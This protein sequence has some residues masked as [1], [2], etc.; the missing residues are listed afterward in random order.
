MS[1]AAWA[2]CVA[3]LLVTTG[4]NSQEATSRAPSSLNGSSISIGSC[5]H[6]AAQDDQGIQTITFAI[7]FPPGP[8][9]QIRL[10]VDRQGQMIR[11]IE[12]AARLSGEH[13]VIETVGAAVFSQDQVVGFYR[14]A[15]GTQAGV[16]SA[17]TRELTQKDALA[18]RETAVWV[19]ER[20]S[21][22]TRR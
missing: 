4:I 13:A 11:Y 7:G 19:K 8:S 17:S 20:C 14:R 3:S 21:S 6:E 16:D 18:I 9:R 22:T 5:G 1:H 12:V 10:D 15:T 2:A